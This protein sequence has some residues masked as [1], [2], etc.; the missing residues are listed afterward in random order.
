MDTS[1]DELNN[2]L[3]ETY[4]ELKDNQE[5]LDDEFKSVLY[6]NLWNLYEW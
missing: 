4:T 5:D 2:Q 6:D 1:D 3:T